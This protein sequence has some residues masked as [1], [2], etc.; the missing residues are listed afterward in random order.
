MLSS[1][2]LR[3]H[4]AVRPSLIALRISLIIRGSVLTWSTK[5]PTKDRND[6]NDRADGQYQT[7][8]H[9]M[10]SASL[11]PLLFKVF[12]SENHVSGWVC[13]VTYQV[14]KVVLPRLPV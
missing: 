10:S 14:L 9:H 2:L 6:H 11:F 12:V 5:V 1:S 3:P 7:E 8:A 4:A 13:N